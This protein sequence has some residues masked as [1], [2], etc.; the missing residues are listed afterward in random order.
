MQRIKTGL[1]IS[2]SQNRFDKIFI[3]CIKKYISKSIDQND[4]IKYFAN[5]TRIILMK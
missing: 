4:A 5:N 3:L 2:M 1:R